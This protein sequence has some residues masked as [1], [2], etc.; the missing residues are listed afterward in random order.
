M[1]AWEGDDEGGW[2]NYNYNYNY[3]NK[4]LGLNYNYNNKDLH[5][6]T[7]PPTRQWLPGLR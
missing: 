5:K 4:G 6:N 2:G 7:H 3:N 1:G